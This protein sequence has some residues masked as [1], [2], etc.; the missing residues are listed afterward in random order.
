[1]NTKAF[2]KRNVSERIQQV[3]LNEYQRIP[4]LG[5]QNVSERIQQ[6]EMNT[7]AW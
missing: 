5:K 1:M 2:G 7:K 4:K 6:V 3:E